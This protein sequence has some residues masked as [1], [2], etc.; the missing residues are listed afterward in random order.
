MT[1]AVLPQLVL[2]IVSGTLL[3]NF[4]PTGKDLCLTAL[5]H[6]WHREHAIVGGLGLHSRLLGTSIDAMTG[7]EA[8]LAN[9]TIVFTSETENSD[10][11][12]AIR[13]A[14]ISSGT[15]ISFKFQTRPEPENVVNLSYT[16]SSTNPENLSAAFKAYHCITSDRNLGRRLSSAAVIIK[17]HCSSVVLFPDR[18]FRLPNSWRNESNTQYGSLLN[19]PHGRNI[20]EY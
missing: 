4:M 19:K 7:A 15:A 10:L 16:I 8:V 13:D 17:T 5:I 1:R 11:Y 3:R 18:R 12:W 2:V 9:G 20:Q 6:S 14:G